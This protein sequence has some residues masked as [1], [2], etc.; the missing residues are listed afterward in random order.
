M[1]MFRTFAILSAVPKASSK[2]G[3]CSKHYIYP[4]KI[5][6][7]VQRM[8]FLCHAAKEPDCTLFEQCTYW[9]PWSLT[10]STPLFCVV[11]LGTI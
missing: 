1:P 6:E 3:M 2:S 9:I 4:V 8:T 11:L 5:D 10:F 7:A